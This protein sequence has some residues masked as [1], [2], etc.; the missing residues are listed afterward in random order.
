MCVNYIIY[1]EKNKMSVC[2]VRGVR[3]DSFVAVYMYQGFSIDSSLKVN[4][5]LAEGSRSCG[6]RQFLIVVKTLPH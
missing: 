6:D 1:R 5:F 2:R 4:E 3:R